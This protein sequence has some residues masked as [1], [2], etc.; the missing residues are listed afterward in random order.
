MTKTTR[1]VSLEDV[2][3]AMVKVRQVAKTMEERQAVDNLARHLE[4]NHEPG[5]VAQFDEAWERAEEIWEQG[6]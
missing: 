6:S 5:F 4:E 3:D 2:I 1:T